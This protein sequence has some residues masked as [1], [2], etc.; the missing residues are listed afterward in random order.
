MKDIIKMVVVLTVISVVAGYLLATTNK[1]TKA[2][3]AAARL[4][5]KL[6]AMKK[7]LPDYDNDPVANTCVVKEAGK[8]WTFYVARKQGVFV[9]A[10]FEASSDQ[11]YNG[12]IRILAGI[13]P[14]NRIKGLEIVEQAETPGLGAKISESAFKD[15]FQGKAI[16]STR[17][18]VK[19]DGGD[20]DAITGATISPRAVVS[21]LETG[22]AVYT[23]NFDKI[24]ATADR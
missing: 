17:W 11:G 6:D 21:A 16:F 9:G 4:A 1:I 10:A 5:E 7:V 15:Q 2:P 8:E 20:I 14:D 13:L 22:L 18:M 19:K 12:T 24:A 23:N 3:I